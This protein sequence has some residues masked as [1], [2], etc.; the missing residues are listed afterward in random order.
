MCQDEELIKFYKGLYKQTN[1]EI[2]WLSLRGTGYKDAVIK[3][4]ED[5]LGKLK[6]LRYL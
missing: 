3:P 6:K 2:L 5:N 1:L 4:L